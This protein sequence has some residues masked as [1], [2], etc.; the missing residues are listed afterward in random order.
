M[1][2]FKK[3]E[4]TFEVRSKSILETSPNYLNF[5]EV[6]GSFAL[7]SANVWQ[8]MFE[9]AAN[10]WQN[11]PRVRQ[12][13]R[14]AMRWAT[15]AGATL[16]AACAHSPD[17]RETIAD[18]EAASAHGAQEAMTGGPAS[19]GAQVAIQTASTQSRPLRPIIITND[20][21]SP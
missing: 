7:N 14:R 5:L 8:K 21:G 10:C 2:L 6:S 12:H 1:I 20:R 16:L 11:L 9:A 4:R 13:G 17:V 19:T 18:Y 15:I 3:K